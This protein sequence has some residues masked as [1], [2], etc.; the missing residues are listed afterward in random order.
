MK[1]HDHVVV[2]KNRLAL[3]R[4]F[5]SLRPLRNKFISFDN[6]ANTFPLTNKD[7]TKFFNI[8]LKCYL[9]IESS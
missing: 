8:F 9:F 7:K 6:R 3:R 4:D 5:M 1:L 2:R